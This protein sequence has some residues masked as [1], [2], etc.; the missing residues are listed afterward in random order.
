MFGHK[1]F[2]ALRGFVVFALACSMAA[3]ASA[4]PGERSFDKSASAF[5][6]SAFDVAP[7]VANE[8]SR[9]RFQR[10]ISLTCN[11][12]NFC[13]ANF[14]TVPPKTYYELDFATCYTYVPGSGVVYEVY[15]RRS[16]N[17][18]PFYQDLALAWLTNRGTTNLY[19][20]EKATRLFAHPGTTLSAVITASGTLSFNYCNIFGDVVIV[21]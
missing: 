11:A 12:S 7:S 14:F 17:G 18:P 6:G 4:A 1:A 19:S 5:A 2:S 8:I 20:F 10:Q 16:N 3:S 15:L 9:T 13:T 21:Q